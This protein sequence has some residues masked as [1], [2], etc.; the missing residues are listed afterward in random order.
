MGKLCDVRK[1]CHARNLGVN[2]FEVPK[3][4]LP[5]SPSDALARV[6]DRFL[7]TANQCRHFGD[8]SFRA[9]GLFKSPDQPRYAFVAVLV[10]FDVLTP[11]S[12]LGE[13]F[14]LTVRVKAACQAPQ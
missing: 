3:S 6:S 5:V 1:F 8:S 7:A 11:V 9:S 2:F 13:A 10:G 4:A 14:V 12:D